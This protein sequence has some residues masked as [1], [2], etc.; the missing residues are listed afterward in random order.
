M[1][2]LLI[3]WILLAAACSVGGWLLSAFGELNAAGYAVWFL[4]CFILWRLFRGKRRG[5]SF[6]RDRYGLRKLRGRFRR[7]LPAAFLILCGLILAGGLL[8]PPNNYDGLSYRIPRML[9]WW[10]A[11][12]WHWIDGPDA[13]LNNRVCGFEWLTIPLLVLFKSDRLFFLFNFISYLFLPGLLFSFLTRVGVR[14]KIAWY[15]MWIFPAGYGFALQAGGI[16]NDGI[17]AL[18]SVAMIEFALRARSSGNPAH[19][20]LSLISA[21]LMT[22]AKSNTLPLLL[23]WAWAIL[24]SLRLLWLRPWLTLSGGLTALAA[25]TFPTICANL[26]YLH[27]WAGYAKEDWV[28]LVKN[29]VIGVAVNSIVLLIQNCAPP[30]FPFASQWNKFVGANLPASWRQTLVENFEADW[31]ELRELPSEEWA[32]VGFAVVLCLAAAI[33]LSVSRKSTAKN[34]AYPTARAV[35]LDGLRVTPWIS[36]AVFMAKSGMSMVSRM[37]LPYAPLLLPLIVAKFQ[38]SAL[39]KSRLFRGLGLFALLTAMLVVVITPARPL[40]PA[41]TLLATARKTLGDSPLLA[42][43]GRVFAT[44]RERHDNFRI[45]RE[46][47]PPTERQIGLISLPDTQETSLW[48]PYGTRTVRHISPRSNPRDL[49]GIHYV[50]AGLQAF[51]STGRD[52]LPQWLQRNHATIVQSA[53]ITFRAASPD[54]ENVL[55]RLDDPNEAIK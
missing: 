33:W 48:L 36:L 29:P 44:Y 9:H 17:V 31:F 55:I 2:E 46:R 42:R 40:F 52:S 43:A 5:G 50:I 38:S 27:D 10:S 24:P 8:Y 22:G 12:G 4:G 39:E 28:V 34:V 11:G 45:L 26:F 32:G 15:W 18:Y 16:G 19:A 20:L 37:T 1:H 41:Q 6:R 51:N 7:T 23:P 13:R 30:I 14:N 35:W 25:S 53:P 21:A 54:L 47:I 3:L 49:Q